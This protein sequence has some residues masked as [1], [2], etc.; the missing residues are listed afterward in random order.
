MESHLTLRCM[1][2]YDSTRVNNDHFD[3]GISKILGSIPVNKLK[4]FSLSH[5]ANGK[6]AVFCVFME[7]LDDLPL[8][9]GLHTKI[10]WLHKLADIIAGVLKIE[11]QELEVMGIGSDDEGDFDTDSD[12]DIGPDAVQRESAKT[13]A[14]ATRESMAQLQ[15]VTTWRDHLHKVTTMLDLLESGK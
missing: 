12:D 5:F 3:A 4:V 7:P 2:R 11:Q 13:K 9:T 15:R 10:A 1:V 8:P 6:D 14:K